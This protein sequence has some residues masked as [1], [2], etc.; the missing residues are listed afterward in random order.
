MPTSVPLSSASQAIKA[1]REKGVLAMLVDFRWRWPPDPGA[2]SLARTQ[3]RPASARRSN[4][5]RA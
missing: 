1:P 3:K 4:M 5:L 2:R